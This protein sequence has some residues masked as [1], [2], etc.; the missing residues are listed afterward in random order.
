VL[1]LK[2]E[3]YS[4]TSFQAADIFEFAT[5]PG[6]WRMAAKH[7]K[8]S[9]GE[10]HRSW[11]K[12]AFVRSLQRLIPELTSDDWNLEDPACE[13]KRWIWM[14]NSSTIFISF[15]TDGIV[16]VSNVPS[17]AATASLA[18]ARHIVDIVVQ[19]ADRNVYTLMGPG[20][21]SSCRPGRG[22][23]STITPFKQERVRIPACGARFADLGEIVYGDHA[24]GDAAG[25]SAEVDHSPVFKQNTWEGPAAGKKS[26]PLAVVLD[27][28][29]L[30]QAVIGRVSRLTIAPPS[31]KETDSN[32]T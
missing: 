21:W 32:P 19:H 24:T 7:W 10:Y 5:F 30:A 11:S 12:A 6:F 14:A 22:S 9:L 13:R 28:E 17:P 8:M 3:G 26:R 15:Y 31:I 18:I 16:H 23:R 27:A 4:K 2:R 20:R 1:A 25:E 29:S